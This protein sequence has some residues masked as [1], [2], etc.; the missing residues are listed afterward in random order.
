MSIPVYRTSE[1]GHVEPVEYRMWLRPRDHLRPVGGVVHAADCTEAPPNAFAL[2]L[3]QAL[4]AAERP[5]VRLCTLC[6]A[7]AELDPVLRGFAQGFDN[8]PDDD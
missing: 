6:G 5:G 1:D 8:R 3:D 2:T 4:N 7:S